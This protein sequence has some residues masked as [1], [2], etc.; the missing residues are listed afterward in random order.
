MFSRS[1]ILLLAASGAL[2]CNPVATNQTTVVTMPTPGSPFIPRIVRQRAFSG[3]T[4]T[5]ELADGTRRAIVSSGEQVLISNPA[6]QQVHDVERIP[7]LGLNVALDPL[8]EYLCLTLTSKDGEPLIG[9]YDLNSRTLLWSAPAP[10][11]GMMPFATPR[12]CLFS[13]EAI[14]RFDIRTGAS[15][16]QNVV[17]SLKNN[18]L[19]ARK[20]L[21]SADFAR[22]Y[23]LQLH[24]FRSSAP[25][26]WV[27]DPRNTRTLE[28]VG[29]FVANCV[30][31]ARQG[32]KIGLH[33]V[34]N[35]KQKQTLAK[36]L[37]ATFIDCP[38]LTMSSITP[39]KA[40]EGAAKVDAP[41]SW[42][43]LPDK[44]LVHHRSDG[45]FLWDWQKRRPVQ[46]LSTEPVPSYK[47]AKGVQIPIEPVVHPDGTWV[48]VIRVDGTLARW[49][50]STGAPL[51]PVK[52]P[53][54]GANSELQEAKWQIFAGHADRLAAFRDEA[55]KR[56]LFVG[57]TNG[58]WTKSN[59]EMQKDI[60]QYI[61][62]LNDRWVLSDPHYGI[63]QITPKTGKITVR[64][65]YS[66]T[67]SRVS[68]AVPSL[69][70][71]QLAVIVNESNSDT[72]GGIYILETRSLAVVKK[73]PAPK[74]A[75]ALGEFVWDSTGIL[76]LV[77]NG[78]AESEFVWIDLAS[79][80][81]R[82][83]DRESA[84][85]KWGQLR[86]SSTRLWRNADGDLVLGAQFN[87]DDAIAGIASGSAWIEYPDGRVWC[88]GTGCEHFRCAADAMT[89]APINHKACAAL[90][91]ENP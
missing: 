21:W 22:F 6:T 64:F 83:M 72:K 68:R 24:S 18:S 67:Q 38:P 84:R 36:S 27:V 35:E 13:G 34:E 11:T 15:S 70:G 90:R 48:G 69:D 7:G 51:P 46:Q 19:E 3:M 62:E 30:E 78:Q 60:S 41:Q 71:K 43:Q 66:D 81:A 17:P 2:A 80:E 61:E 47:N 31:V 39:L 32:D 53:T 88:D 91:V 20:I 40:P 59:A 44:R 37:G 50:A 73:L 54:V 1:T 74:A 9:A 42:V 85:Q 49:D 87:T 4:S 10:K 45:L 89:L 55:G 79:G 58:A 12:E 29:T 28:S 52:L 5:L 77:Q 25:I 16:G 57:T 26:G 33:P 65:A 23:N 8:L 14:T 75:T 86:T 76:R 63:Q 56:Q 82:T